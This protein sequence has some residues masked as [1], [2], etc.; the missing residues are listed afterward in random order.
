MQYSSLSTPTPLQDAV[1]QPHH[2]WVTYL[3]AQDVPEDRVVNGREELP[4]VALEDVGEAA[5][6]FLAAVQRPVGAFADPVGVG[7]GNERALKEGLDDPYQGVVDD[8]VPEGGGG[9]EA[10]LRVVDVEGVVRAGLIGLEHQF[11]LQFQQVG[12]Q[13]KLKSGDVGL[14]PLSPRRRPVGQVQVLKGTYLRI[15]MFEGLCHA[16]PTAAG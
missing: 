12:F 4:D 6:E 5:G 3:M 9:D 7:I 1:N 15:E 13:V 16:F 2:V 11:P 10:A 8:P 14:S